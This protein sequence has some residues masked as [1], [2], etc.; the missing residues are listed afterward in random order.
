LA[1][2]LLRL[3]AASQKFRRGGIAI[4]A[5]LLLLYAGTTALRALEWSHPL[6]FAMTEAAKH[7]QSPRATY[8]L[9]RDYVILSGFDPTSPYVDKALAALQ[10]AASAPHSTPLPES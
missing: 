5:G 2:L 7:P 1:D 4:A 10:Q 3:P 8:D 9:A 6:R